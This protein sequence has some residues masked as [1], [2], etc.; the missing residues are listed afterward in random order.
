MTAGTRERAWFRAR[1]NFTIGGTAVKIGD[2]IDLSEFD[3]PP[4][5]STA[6]ERSGFG[7]RVTVEQDTP[8]QSPTTAVAEPAAE[9]VDLADTVADEQPIEQSPE[10]PPPSEWTE[11]GLYEMGVRGLADMLR[12]HGLSVRGSKPERVDRLLKFQQEGG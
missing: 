3:L 2:L 1:R 6:L 5:R 4:N 9:P 8:V 12:H 7:E 10:F 11:A